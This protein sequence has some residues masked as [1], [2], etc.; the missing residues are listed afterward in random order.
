MGRL[1]SD[2]LLSTSELDT[3]SEV[4]VSPADERADWDDCCLDLGER[5]FEEIRARERARAREPET[6]KRA[7][8]AAE[9]VP[10]PE[11]VTAAE[12]AAG[13]PWLPA[14]G[15]VAEAPSTA[16]VSLDGLVPETPAAEVR[17][18]DD[19]AGEDPRFVSALYAGLTIHENELWRQV[20]AEHAVTLDRVRGWLERS[21]ELGALSP[22]ERAAAGRVLAVLGDRRRGVGL[23]GDGLP[24]V[25]WVEVPAGSFRMG[26]GAGDKQSRNLEKP[27]HDV[28]LDAF[29]ISRVPV[30]HAQYQAFVDAGGSRDSH[31]ECR[32]AAGG[33]WTHAP[34][35]P[36]D[37]LPPDYLLAN[38]PRVNVS[39]FE[40]DAFSRWLGRQLGASV[41]LPTEAEWEKAARGIDARIYP[42][43][44]AFDAARCNVGSTGI[45]QP[46]AAGMFPSGASPHGVLDMSGNV[47]EWTLS[48]VVDYADRAQG[49][50]A[51]AIS[52]EVENARQAGGA[53]RVFR[54]VGFFGHARQARCAYRHGSASRRANRGLGFRVLLP[55]PEPR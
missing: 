24:D 3:G 17:I 25:D 21:L 6:S 10:A 8:T 11:V 41:R 5:L 34:Q 52:R 28:T 19:R 15:R 30:T 43:G 1:R 9:V 48:E 45:G 14:A 16:W 31:R 27:Q 40:A 50:D 33:E 13:H 37:K 22:A 51:A 53:A 29:A 47:W 18:T 4:T 54:G 42:W 44:D 46:S 39:W 35:G 36:D 26:S 7:L 49:V 12:V 38:H 23:K 55:V 2:D 32:P 20:E